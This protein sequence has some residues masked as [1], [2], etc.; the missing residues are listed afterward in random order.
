MGLWGCV[1]LVCGAVCSGT[2]GL[3]GVRVWCCAFLCLVLRGVSV[4]VLVCLCVPRW[5]CCMF[6]F[7]CTVSRVVAPLHMVLFL[8]KDP[9]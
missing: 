7:V 9:Q 5:G 2:V 4:G 3:V 6:G 1:L 8:T